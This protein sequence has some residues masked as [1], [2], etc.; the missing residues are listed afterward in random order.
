MAGVG[1]GV[2]AHSKTLAEFTT[3]GLAAFA[4]ADLVG[5]AALIAGSTVARVANHLGFTTIAVVFITI[6]PSRITGNDRAFTLDADALGP[7]D[8]WADPSIVGGSTLLIALW[9]TS[10]ARIPVQT[11]AVLVAEVVD[12]AGFVGDP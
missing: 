11:V 5:I 4:A 1:T 3:V 7:D 8:L 6:T 9:V 10:L 2:A 12:E